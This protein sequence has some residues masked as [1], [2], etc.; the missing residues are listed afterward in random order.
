LKTNVNSQTPK[1]P[2]QLFIL[3]RF[4]QIARKTWAVFRLAGKIFVRIDAVQ[5]AGAFAFNAFFSLFPLMILLATIASFF[6]DRE[7]ASKKTIAFMEYYIPISDKTQSYVLGTIAGVVQMRGKAGVIAFIAL[8]WIIVQSFITLISAANR[9]WGTELHNWWRM[10]LRSLA[11]TGVTAG[12]L[13]IGMAA[14]VLMKMTRGW[15]FTANGFSYWSNILANFFIPLVVMF[16]GLSL[17]YKLAPRHPTRFSQVWAAALFATVLVQAAENLFVIYLNHF[18]AFNAVYGAFG[19][20]M[21]LLLWIYYSGCIFIF[22][23]CLCSSKA[24]LHSQPPKM[25]AARPDKKA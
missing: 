12:A 18:G 3:S 25:I 13:L 22:G 10:P 15:P 14:P 7:S 24:E 1:K 21:V 2:H 11:L 23:A 16:I 6:I 4:D 9:A 17:F 19:G 8:I 5:W 20:I